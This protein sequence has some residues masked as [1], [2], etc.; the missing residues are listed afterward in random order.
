MSL[1]THVM[2]ESSKDYSNPSCKLERLVKDGK[3]HRIIRG[4]FETDPDTP[5][6]LLAQAICSPSYLSFEYALSRSIDC[7]SALS[8]VSPFIADK[9][10]LENR[11]PELYVQVAER[12]IFH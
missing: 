6:E 1:T 5:G 11:S 7:R 8:D 4:L 10:K 12:L 3:Y 9:K 2:E